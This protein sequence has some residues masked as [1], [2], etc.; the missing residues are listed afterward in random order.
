MKKIFLLLVPVF[1]AIIIFLVV[2]F[3]LDP[4]FGKGAL[5]V[6]S[7]PESNVY[8]DGKLI[9]KTPLCKCELQNMLPSGVHDIK[10]IP[11]S[12][13]L[14]TYEERITITKSTLTVIDRTFNNSSSEGSVINLTSLDNK[15]SMEL[16]VISFPD[17]SDVFL[18]NNMV[19]NT[20]LLLKDITQSD[21]DLTLKKDGYKDKTIKIRTALGY[22]LNAL[23]SLGIN[24]VTPITVSSTS[25][26]SAVPSA[27]VTIQKVVILQTPTGDLNVRESGSLDS[28]K[29]SKV[30]PG[31]SFDLVD[32]KD[33]WLEIKLQNGKTGWISAVY[34]KKE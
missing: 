7:I 24:L 27:V 18:D 2:T 31:D 29:I 25:S 9:G 28:P 19:G 33:N 3:F 13:D 26:S 23:I 5:Q 21:H 34:A 10:L 20:P 14:R 32:E 30:Y 12:G 6:T 15:N 17:K 22:R 1:V 16:S 4:S 8:L 11:T